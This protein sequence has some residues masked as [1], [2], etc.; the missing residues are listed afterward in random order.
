MQGCGPGDL[1]IDWL[2][3]IIKP[4][5][6][7]HDVCYDLGEQTRLECDNQFYKDIMMTTQAP[8]GILF[9]IACMC[10]M[11]VRAFGKRYYNGKTP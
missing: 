4:A 1:Q 3:T 11:F 8:I 10:W 7:A 9:I 5:C 6:E 2:N